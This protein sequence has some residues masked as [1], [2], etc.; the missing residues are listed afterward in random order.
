MSAEHDKHPSGFRVTQRITRDARMPLS[1]DDRE[2]DHSWRCIPVPPG[3]P[4]EG[5]QVLDSSHDFK[6][7][8][9][10]IARDYWGTTR[11]GAVGR[12]V[13][14]MLQIKADKPEG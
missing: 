7:T 14:R 13:A 10:R 12:V 8:W 3:P 6:T 9:H 2:M 11:L 5:W 1:D 4:E